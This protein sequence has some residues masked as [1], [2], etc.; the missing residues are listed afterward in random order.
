[1]GSV[2]TFIN[3]MRYWCNEGNLGYDQSQRWD[4]F[5]GGECDCSTLVIHALQE[6]GFDTGSAKYTGNMKDNLIARGW[7]VVENN[8]YPLPGDILLNES[9]HVAVWLGDCLA[10]ASIDENGNI[11]GGAAGDQSGCET[12]TCGYY[13]YPWDFYLRWAD[14][15]EEPYN[16]ST[17]EWQGE[18]IGLIDTTGFC[19]NFAGCTGRP[20]LMLATDVNKYQAHVKGGSWLEPVGSYNPYDSEYGCAGDFMP[21]DA[22]RIYD[23]DVY[24]QTHNIDGTWNDV[25]HGLHDTG[26]SGDDFAGVYG[27]AQDAIRIWRDKGTQPRY[28]VFA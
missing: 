4:I 10:Q 1:M 15:N 22:I 2:Q 21:I 23:E 16:P 7:I 3:R 27:I 19:E 9:D 17:G 20:M 13:N 6:A 11:S 5:E 26:G 28:N 12:N 24:Y 18:M 14:N 25:M 8:G